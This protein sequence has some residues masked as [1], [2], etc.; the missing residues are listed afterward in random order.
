M[1]KVE[2]HLSLLYFLGKYLEKPHPATLRHANRRFLPPTAQNHSI[3]K[4]NLP[5]SED[6]LKRNKKKLVS[7]YRKKMTELAEAGISLDLE[8]LVSEY[9]SLVSGVL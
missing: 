8:D 7:K 1:L 3:R 9:I 6:T 4:H 5:K 2:I